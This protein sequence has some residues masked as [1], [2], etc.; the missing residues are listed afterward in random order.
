VSRRKIFGTDGIR[1]KANSYPMT[2]EVATALGRAVT[3]Y[4]QTGNQNSKPPVI[5]VGKDTRLSCYMLEQAFGAGVC[6]QGGQVIFT[7]PLPTPGVAFVTKSMRADAGIMI[8][9][10]HNVFTD[11]G[12]KIF[13]SKGYKLPDQVE[14]KLEELVLNPDQM[15]VMEGI[16]LGG[17][18]RLD[19]VFGRYV[20]YA[21]SAFSSRY[22]LEHMR[23][24]LDCA[25]GAAYKVGP[26]IFRE[27]GAEVFPIGVTPNGENI[28]LNC[29]SLYPGQAQEAVKEYRAD[30]GI[31][32][33]GDADRFVIVDG[34]GNKVHGDQLLGV[35]AKFLLDTEVLK[36]GDEVIGTV[37]SNV[38]L[39][40]FIKS[41][42]LEF[43]RT[44]V[45]DRYI[46][47]YMKSSGTVFGGE[48]SGHIIFKNF[49]TT[50]D[51]LLG[52]LKFIECLKFYNIPLDKLVSQVPLFPQVTKSAPVGVKRPLEEVKPI[53][54]KLEDVKNQLG[55]KGRVVL[56]YSGTESLARIMVEGENEVHVGQLCDELASV[57]EQELSSF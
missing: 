5:V 28:N 18:K 50:G 54:E 48:P 14:M 46:M 51:G 27:L 1:G 32:L 31:C 42:G 37:M 25:H 40:Y 10:S 13:D 35:L 52:A 9:A 17:A 15:P 49:S 47:E 12:I 16:K 23:I 34:N 19:E 6:S 39:E 7:G 3:H 24:V 36:R 26:M 53:Q 38:G 20:V 11:N 22:D 29:G 44:K 55:N 8:S 2:C 4:F 43:H 21:K 33:D 45:G 30:I 56:R 57:V 41:L